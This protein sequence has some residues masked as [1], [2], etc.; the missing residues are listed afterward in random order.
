MSTPSAPTAMAMRSTRRGRG[1]S[2]PH[3]LPYLVRLLGGV[4]LSGIPTGP[5]LD[6]DGH[7]GGVEPDEKIDFATP[8]SDIAT[9]HDRA[10]IFEEDGG[11]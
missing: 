7:Q 1:L 3:R 2:R 10:S 9:Y 8:G 11:E 6:L 4:G 5:R